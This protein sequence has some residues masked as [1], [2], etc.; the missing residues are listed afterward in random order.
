M[1]RADKLLTVGV[2][3]AAV[4]VTA[5]MFCRSTLFS[6]PTLAPRA[7]ISARGKVVRVVDLA[8]GKG[9]TTFTVVGR[10]GPAL[11]EAAGNRIR[12]AEA[13]CA[14]HICTARGW[15]G[16]PGEAVVCVPGEIL[17]QIE[18]AAPVDAVT[19]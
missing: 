1:T 4:L 11:V 7:V 15:I 5:A 16:K 17:I 14:R 19:R 18:G 9:S 6:H 10:E 8:A 12:M 2:L 13:P 3:L